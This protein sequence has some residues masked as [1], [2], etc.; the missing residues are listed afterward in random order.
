MNMSLYIRGRFTIQT[1]SSLPSLP[2]VESLDVHLL[3]APCQLLRTTSLQLSASHT[4]L[5]CLPA[6][7]ESSCYI[8]VQVLSNHTPTSAIPFPPAVLC[9][10]YQRYTTPTLIKKGATGRMMFRIASLYNEKETKNHVRIFSGRV[11]YP[12]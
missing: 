11:A 3:L 5:L 1:W 7:M 12:E 4:S 9:H 10:L 2:H 8:T 6:V